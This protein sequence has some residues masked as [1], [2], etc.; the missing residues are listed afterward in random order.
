M[1]QFDARIDVE[2]SHLILD[3]GEWPNFHDAEV[4]DLNIWRGDVRPDADVWI[5]PV[6]VATFELCALKEPYIAVLKFHDCSALTM[7]EFNHQNAVYDLTFEYEGR[8][9]DRQGNPLLPFV[10]VRFEQAFDVALSFKCF[11]VQAIERREL[12]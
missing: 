7:T 4:H 9:D 2:D 8:G 10:R 1:K 11:R 12:G 6:I 3:E 5:G